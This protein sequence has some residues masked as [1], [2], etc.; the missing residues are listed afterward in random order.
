MAQ[1]VSPG[2]IMVCILILTTPATAQITVHSCNGARIDFDGVPDEPAWEQS[3]VMDDF[4]Q[5]ELVSGAQP[6]ER[7]EV[8]FLHDDANLYIGINCFDS[9]PSGIIAKQMKQDQ[10]PASD[11]RI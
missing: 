1:R 4:T 8:R 6:T 9:N 5:F 3:E 11:D 2:F 10:D 7:T